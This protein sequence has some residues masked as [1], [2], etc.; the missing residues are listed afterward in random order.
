MQSLAMH[1]PIPCSPTAMYQ[2]LILDPRWSSTPQSLPATQ[3]WTQ[4]R[5]CNGCHW[6]RRPWR[7][8]AHWHSGR[9]W[10]AL[11]SR[12]WIQEADPRFWAIQV[13]I[14]TSLNGPIPWPARA[15]PLHPKIVHAQ[16]TILHWLWRILRSRWHTPTLSTQPV[17]PRRC[18]AWP[19]SCASAIPLWWTSREWTSEGSRHCLTTSSLT[20]WEA[21]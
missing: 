8:G 12:W 13:G 19:W 14:S 16:A 18:K 15:G 21:G 4:S 20:T 10:P 17:C 3:C 7:S 2:L 6:S 9:A 5:T 11:L 1:L